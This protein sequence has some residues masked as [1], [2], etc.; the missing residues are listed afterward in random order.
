MHPY[1][2]IPGMG[3]LNA[4][5]PIQRTSLLGFLV[6][7]SVLLDV[8]GGRFLLRRKDTAQFGNGLGGLE[9]TPSV[10][11]WLGSPQHGRRA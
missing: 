11:L 8:L 6:K 10:F 7:W 3:I 2:S 9:W 4:P 5:D 1:D